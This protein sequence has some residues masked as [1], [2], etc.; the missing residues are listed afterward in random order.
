MLLPIYSVC[1]RGGGQK[2]PDSVKNYCK[3]KSGRS[4]EFPKILSLGD[5]VLDK[6]EGWLISVYLLPP[7]IVSPSS[8]STDGH[9]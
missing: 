1:M 9:I 3:F 6:H 8:S 7:P 5:P 4:K 2:G